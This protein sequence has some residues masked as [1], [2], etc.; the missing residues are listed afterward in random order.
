MREDLDYVDIKE[1][2]K[3]RQRYLALMGNTMLGIAIMDTSHR[4]LGV[5][6]KFSNMFKKEV[7]EFIGGYCFKEFEKRDS[8]CPHCP[9]IQALQTHQ[10]S[11]VLTQGVLDNGEKFY[12]WNRAFPVYREDG[13]VEG[14]IEVVEDI[15][16]QKIAEEEINKAYDQLKSIQAQLIQSEKMA[17]IGQLAAGVAHEINNPT[18]YVL[19][20]LEVLVEDVNTLF[21][22]IEDVEILVKQFYP[23][24]K[25]DHDDFYKEFD[26]IVSSN[27][28]EFLKED[29]PNLI[30]ESIEG[31]ERIKKIVYNLKNF[32]HPV[33]EGVSEVDINALIDTALELV[34]NE[35]K[36]RCK[37]IKNYKELPRISAN[38]Q[39]LEQVFVN[40]I[41]NAS[42][43]IDNCGVININ[44][45][46]EGKNVFIVIAD[47]GKGIPEEN[48]DKIFDPF[49]TTKMVGEGTGLG[50]AI[51]YGIIKDNKGKIEV[52]ST[53]GEGTKFTISF[54]V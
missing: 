22:V 19:A 48:I 53:V 6:M 47:D 9:G 38:K 28:L 25:G 13:E 50:L 16:K 51:V 3:I 34:I 23:K 17:G 10:T 31:A 45:Y 20:N 39:Q 33:Q 26:K 14:F 30:K 41:I 52:E 1:L 8:I 40:I 2:I 7:G 43:A 37:V 27:E 49:F 15:T 12:A 18:G 11:E 21:K 4:I 54:P 46:S 44:T 5:N 35:I 36:Y 29:L 24:K 42:Q 32:V